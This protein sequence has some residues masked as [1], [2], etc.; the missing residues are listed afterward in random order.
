MIQHRRPSASVAAPVAL[1]L[2]LLAAR[3]ALSQQLPVTP[4]RERGN[5][6]FDGIPPPDP[7]LEERLRRYLQSRT[8]TFLDWTADGSMLVL[9]RF[10]DTE[11][12]H[13]VASPLGMREQLTFYSDPIEWAHA[14]KSGNRSE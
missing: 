6:V 4:H 9:T 2:A 5:L 1:L 3:A 8:G 11:Q 14:A 7:A 13:R 10:T 12:V